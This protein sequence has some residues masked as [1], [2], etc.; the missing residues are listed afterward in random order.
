[1]NPWLTEQS[2]KRT[3]LE[4]GVSVVKRTLCSCSRPGLDSKHQHDGFLTSVT[5][6][7]G[8]SNDF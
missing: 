3:D 8:K 6:D 5:T 2:S 4:A 1:M 7:P